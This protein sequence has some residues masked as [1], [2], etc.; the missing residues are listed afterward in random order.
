MVWIMLLWWSVHTPC[1]KEHG[2]EG[3]AGLA[4]RR[5]QLRWG[6]RGGIGLHVD[7]QNGWDPGG[8]YKKGR[9]GLEI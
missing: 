2:M 9:K 4:G 8:G 7:L 3:L 1:K 5:E 6:R